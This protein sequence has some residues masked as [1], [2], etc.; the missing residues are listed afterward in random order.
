MKDAHSA[1]A[2][3]GA[4]ASPA[5]LSPWSRFC[6]GVALILLFMFGLGSLAQ[7]VPGAREM[8]AVIESHDLRATAIYYTDFEQPAD[9]SERIRDSLDFAPGTRP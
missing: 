1:I 7:R 4:I 2:V 5:A 6:V 3:G 8:A 9:G